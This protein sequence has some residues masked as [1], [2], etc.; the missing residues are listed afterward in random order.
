MSERS[1]GAETTSD[2]IG[3]NRLWLWLVLRLNRWLLTAIILLVTFLTLVVISVFDVAPV[4]LTAAEHDSVEALFSAFI[5]AIITGTTIV[6]TI[7]Q[8][9]LSQELGAVGDQRDRMQAASK[10]RQ[11]AEKI[12]EC[13]IS[14]PQ[15]AA[16]LSALLSG[17]E[18]QVEQVETAI[19]QT[20]DEQLRE[21]LTEYLD[22]LTAN[23]QQ[24]REQLEDA[25]FGSFEVIWAALGFN[26]SWQIYRLRQIRAT[27]TD[28]ISAEADETIEELIDALRLFAPAREHFKTLYFQWKLIDLSRALLYLAVP[29]LVV[30]AVF[31]LFVDP[32][33]FPGES[34]GVDNMVLLTSFGFTVGIAPFVVFI[35]YVIRIAT[36]AK[37]T[38]AMGPMILQESKR[39]D[40]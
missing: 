32:D 6:V 36:V 33:T 2:Q 1:D 29:A 24:V 23:A 3:G 7:N 18:A 4:R 21:E 16:F 30:M 22:G 8:L 14:P 17:I 9:V 20:G 40:D 34:L 26:Y 15:P 39:G 27:H 31:V 38:L 25:P 5:G 10:F 12:M 37:Q 35:V 19:D 11:D 28:A 13:S